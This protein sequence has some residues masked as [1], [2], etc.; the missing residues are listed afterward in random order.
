MHPNPR[1]NFLAVFGK[2]WPK[3]CWRPFR[4][5]CLT[6][7]GNPGSA[8]VNACK[9]LLPPTND[10]CEGNVF[11]GVRLSGG[12]CPGGMCVMGWSVREGKVGGTPR[13][14][15]KWAVPILLECILVVLFTDSHKPLDLRSCS[16]V[17]PLPLVSPRSKPRSTTALL[18]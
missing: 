10:V 13:Y 18:K 16:V 1:S 14:G 17:P 7:P 4:V 6:V 15:K 9:Y 5:N 11:T 3:I 2:F 8:S 12:F